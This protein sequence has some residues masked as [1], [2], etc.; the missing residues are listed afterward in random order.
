ML[1]S[2]WEQSFK[3]QCRSAFGFQAHRLP[4]NM[5]VLWYAYLERARVSL[6]MYIF[7]IHIYIYV[8]N[9]FLFYF[10]VS[11]LLFRICRKI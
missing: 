3:Q 5:N 11:M 7:I 6:Y 2:L 10:A 9:Y 4:M 8:E 1:T